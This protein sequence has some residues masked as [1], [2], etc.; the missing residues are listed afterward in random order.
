[1]QVAIQQIGTVMQQKGVTKEEV[2][3]ILAKRRLARQQKKKGTHDACVQT[4]PISTQKQL[5]GQG[6]KKR[7]MLEMT[8]G[9][10]EPAISQKEEPSQKRYSDFGSKFSVVQKIDEENPPSKKSLA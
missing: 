6:S 3:R 9:E 5:S 2:I 8:F 7:Q 4:S 10:E 1:M